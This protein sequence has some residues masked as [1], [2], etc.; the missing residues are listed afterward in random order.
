MNFKFKLSISKL[1]VLIIFIL[2]SKSSALSQSYMDFKKESLFN[3]STRQPSSNIEKVKIF[4][5][6]KKKF[7]NKLYEPA[8]IQFLKLIEDK[9]FELLDYSYYFLLKIAVQEGQTALAEEYLKEIEKLKPHL[10]LLTEAHEELAFRYQKE[11]KY[12]ESLN[13]LTKVEK[14]NRNTEFYPEVLWNIAINQMNLDKKNLFCQTVMKLYEKFPQFEKTQQWK[15]DLSTNL[16]EGQATGCYSG[17]DNFRDRLRSM[18]LTG[19]LEKAEAEVEEIHAKFSNQFPF[20]S[21]HIKALYYTYNGH[22]DRGLKFIEKYLEERKNDSN[23]LINYATIAARAGF[24]DKA[25]SGYLRVNQLYSGSKVAISSLYQAAIL[26]YQSQ[27]YDGALRLFKELIIKYPNAQ[28]AK[29]SEWYIGWIKYIKG[30]YKAALK[31][32]SRLAESGSRFKRNLRDEKITYWRAMCFYRLD[33]FNEAEMIFQNLAKDKMQGY[34]SL[35]AQMRLKQ[36]KNQPDKLND[37]DAE[38]FSKK[39]AM[40]QVV[41]FNRFDM[42]EYITPYDDLPPGVLQ[43]FENADLDS[44]F[45]FESFIDYSDEDLSS[46]AD[47]LN[48]DEIQNP[49]IPSVEISEETLINLKNDEILVK[50]EKARDLFCLGMQEY[51]K[52]DLFEIEKKTRNKDLLKILMNEYAYFEYYHRSSYL[53]QTTFSSD[54]VK[55]GI[56]GAKALW[57]FAYPPAYKDSV[58]KYSELYQVPQEF[59]WGIMRAESQYKKEARSPVGALGLMQVMPYTGEKIA[60]LLKEDKFYSESL[61]TPDGAVKYGTKYLKR[62]LSFNNQIIP[63]AAASYNAGPHRV[64]NWLSSFGFLD[65]DEFIEHIPFLETRNYVKKVISHTQIY[66]NIYGNKEFMFSFLPDK[67]QMSPNMNHAAKENWDDI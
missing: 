5:T 32:F 39:L 59:V 1:S 15:S 6:A 25:I 17:L 2:I 28:Q 43:K 55:Y 40:T 58:L 33:L 3:K 61:L 16:I 23:F 46:V 38:K 26:G 52:W 50:F 18:S 14:K 44:L 9:K 27:D 12:K 35:A 47:G 41:K 34:Y 36:I 54:R 10:K 21:D 63:L 29:E 65:M 8:K 24:F 53:A 60:K 51:A 31:D 11:K 30:D 19:V 56:D 64:Q 20:E 45:E 13:L 57:Q 62:L 4:E 66:N 37:L 22:P 42:S 67:I 49:D 48:S 7:D